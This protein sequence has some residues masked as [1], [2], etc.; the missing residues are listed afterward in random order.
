MTAVSVST[1]SAQSKVS[2]PDCTQCSTGVTLASA[3]PLRN[4][5]KIGQDSA[6]EMN[7]A[8]V[9]S[10]LTTV[11]PS[12]RL[13]RP[14]MMAASNGRKTMKRIECTGLPLHP[15]DVVDGDRAAA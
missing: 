3:V 5:R 9:V 11:L 14:P 10:D 8:P 1:R 7:S 2:V 4:D 6:Q 15:V 12:A 13:P